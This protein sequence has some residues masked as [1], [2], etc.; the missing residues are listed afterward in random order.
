MEFLLTKFLFKFV[1]GRGIGHLSLRC[2]V[3]HFPLDPILN[4]NPSFNLLHL[5]PNPFNLLLYLPLLTLHLHDTPLNRM[6]P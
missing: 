3:H 2:S 4:C 5:L 6:L 1:V